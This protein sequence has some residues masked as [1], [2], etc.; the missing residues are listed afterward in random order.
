MRSKC[1]RS[2]ARLL[3]AS[4]VFVSGRPEISGQAR[5]GELRQERD[6]LRQVADVGGLIGGLFSGFNVLSV[7]QEREI[8][9]H[10]ARE[11][12]SKQRI[13]RDPE[14]VD[15]VSEVGNRLVDALRRPEFR[16]T[17][18]VVRDPTV[19]AFGIGGGRIFV[20]AGLLAAAATEGQVASVLAHEIGHQVRRHVARAISRQ[21]LFETLAR[22]AVGPN[23]SQWIQ[24]AA[25]LGVT[26][27]ELYFG[28]E[29]EREADVVMVELM[30]SAGYDPREA[31][32]MFDRLRA[33]QGSDPGT[34][35]TIFSS[36][37]PTGERRAAI[38]GEIARMR[39]RSGLTRDS[40]RFQ[41]VRRRVRGASP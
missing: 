19:N 38:A 29:A 14:V 20:N 36:H 30:P 9:R 10:L 17:F 12:E 6:E 5:A 31:I 13:L 37:P 15:F 22:L 26:T 24:L 28:R 27:G 11:V 7:D 23:A 33:V 16:Y 2:F 35:A 4:A 34:V 21:S 39:L 1:H 40:R 25:G 41:E 18:R 3:L 32:A 8:S